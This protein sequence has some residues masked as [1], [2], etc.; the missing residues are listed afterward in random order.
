MQT[1][2]TQNGFPANLTANPHFE[3][4]YENIMKLFASSIFS[5]KHMSKFIK[6]EIEFHTIFRVNEAIVQRLS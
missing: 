5:V 3:I 4:H 1:S 2:S 6:I